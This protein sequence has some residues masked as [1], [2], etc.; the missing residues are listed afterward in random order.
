MSH[1]LMKSATFP[2]MRRS[3]LAAV[4]AATALVALPASASAGTLTKPAGPE[5]CVAD[6]ASTLPPGTCT[7]AKGIDDA[8]DVA[9]SPDGRFAYAAATSSNS[10]AV[11]SRDADS[12]N[13][14]QLDG[15]DGCIAWDGDPI[16]GCA[17]AHGLEGP[18]SLAMSP[19]GK[20]VYVTSF[21]LDTSS[22]TSPVIAGQLTSFSRDASTGVLSEISCAAGSISP[23][24]LLIQPSSPPAGCANAVFPQATA[25]NVPLA[26]ASD[27]EVSPDGKSV[28]TTAFL[29]SAITNWDRNATTG[30]L[31][32]KECWGSGRSLFPAT[33]H[34][35][36]PAL[37]PCINDLGFDTGG[38]VDGMTYPLDLD[39][40]A[41]GHRVYVAG[42]GLEQAA[43]VVVGIEIV[44]AE[45]EPGSVAMFNRNSV[46]RAITQNATTPCIDDSRD[47]VPGDV[48]DHRTALL[49]PYRVN[50]SPDND[51]VY[52][53][54]LNV[55]PPSG[56]AGPG[57]GELSQFDADLSQLDPPCIQQIGLPSGS[58]Q[59]TTGCSLA[60]LGTILPSDI[61]FS[62]DGSSAYVSSLYH[63]VG[64]FQR[65][66]GGLL[67][68]DAAPVGCSIDPRN[69]DEAT[70][71]LGSICQKATPLNA[72]TSITLSP[73]GRDAYVTSGGFLTGNANF[74][75]QLADAGI[76]SDDAITQLSPTPAPE[77]PEEPVDPID[78]VE[79]TPPGETSTC[80]GRVATIV[81]S[82]AGTV[83]GTAGADVIVGTEGNDKIRPGGGDDLVCGGGGNDAISSGAGDDTVL[84]GGG[85]DKVKAGS[86]ND[87]VKGGGGKDRIKGG[88]GDDRLAGGPGKDRLSGGPG[89]DRCASK[90]GDRLSGC[91]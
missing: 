47:P 65:D 84:G 88:S 38:R 4:I 74:G 50:V 43:T 64:S 57:P 85:N 73:D 17:E 76:E 1:V 72:P 12:G 29:P 42:L 90:G 31:T 71:L 14:T 44:P 62:P 58:L 35:L 53:G 37:A 59:P 36:T 54:T 39:I 82:G 3:C 56:L 23:V 7:T 41:D 91:E 28:L 26:T 15:T 21:Q 77:E 69:L 55:F 45:N 22:A 2:D 8:T 52:V 25:R 9:I 40:S 19:D 70:A 24:P 75:P 87:K 30:A 86:G 11:F 18:T 49:N 27:V 5:S 51:S 6:A 10:I 78:P 68:Q 81:A 46:S 20:N 89:K 32:P 80:K 48:C 60:G 33:T 79:P 13:L 83:R 61:A 34:F 66:D 67:T 16:D 63:G